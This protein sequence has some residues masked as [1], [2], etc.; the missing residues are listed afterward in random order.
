M[1]KYYY[2]GEEFDTL[3]SANAAVAEHKTKLETCPSEFIRVKEVTGSAE[4]GWV[5]TPDLLNDEQI[6]AIDPDSDKCYYVASIEHGD[7]K[8]GLTA[9]ETITEINRLLRKY[10]SW[11]NVDKIVTVEETTAQTDMSNFLE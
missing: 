5:M 7:N 4:A 11:A 6:L 9:T 3:E 8:V 2:I 10:G 1:K